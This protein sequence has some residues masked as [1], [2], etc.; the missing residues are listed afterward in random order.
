MK[1]KQYIQTLSTNKEKAA[2]KNQIIIDGV[3]SLADGKIP[4]L[5]LSD[6]HI[7]NASIKF[8]VFIN[9]SALIDNL[10]KFSTFILSQGIFGNFNKIENTKFY[11]S[12]FLLY[13]EITRVHKMHLSN[14]QFISRLID[15]SNDE[16]LNSNLTQI[17]D[18]LKLSD[19]INA[20]L[21]N[22]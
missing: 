18:M 12:Y 8:D 7:D 20:L 15:H 21:N 4:T 19:K 6:W 9:N 3:L 1:I 17:S 14:A 5:S 16:I 11:A 13:S 10:I 22:H 2:V